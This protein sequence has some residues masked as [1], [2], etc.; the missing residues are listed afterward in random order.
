MSSENEDPAQAKKREDDVFRNYDAIN[1]TEFLFKEC[2]SQ[3]D[4]IV[5]QAFERK[6]KIP[7]TAAGEDI[8]EG[9]GWWYES[10]YNAPR[11]CNVSATNKS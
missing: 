9:S 7:K 8:G 11:L 5:P 2:A 1:S 4:Y 6:G 10:M 3:A